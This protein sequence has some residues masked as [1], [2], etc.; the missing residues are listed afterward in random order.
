MQ[1]IAIYGATG[2]TGR[3]VA[4]ELLSRGQDIVLA[5]R[6]GDALRALEA[7]LAAPG[8]VRTHVAAIDDAAALRELA[9]SAAVLIHCAGPFTHT[10]EPVAAACVAAGCHYVDHAIEPHPVKDL[11]ERFQAPA[12]SAGIVMLPQ[13]SFYGGLA[14]LLAAAAT[15]GLP[16]VE[17]VTVGYSVTG[18]RMTPA[19][20]KTAELLIGEID[21]VTFTGGALRVGPVE[22]RNTVFPFPPPIGPRTMIAPFPSG[23]M[24]TIPRHVPA[25]AVESQ[26][27]AATFEEAQI[28]TSQDA[29]A[30]ERA[31]TD[32]MVA[33]QAISTGGGGR[34]AHARGRDI[35]RA[36]ALVSVEAAV[37]IVNGEGPGKA[38]VL[39]AAEAFP[40]VPFLRGLAELGAFELAR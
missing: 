28:F 14:D 34:N 22:I 24:V 31:Q 27:T 25:Q 26:L 33:V 39:A 32:F 38:G 36:G 29:T 11:F 35:W 7:E 13:L 15:E 30:E 4:A 2:H 3:L 19:A 9:G 17:R 12:R 40:A 18:W 1:L 21:R 6:D 23:E 8:R 37:R 16:G 5:G 20:V 10:A